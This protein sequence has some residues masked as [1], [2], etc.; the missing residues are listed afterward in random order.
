MVAIFGPKSATSSEHIRSIADSMEIPYVETRWNYRPETR[1]PSSTGYAFNLHPD[2]STLSKAYVDVLDAFH[3]KTV[4]ILYQ[5]NN[6][7]MTLRELFAK[8]SKSNEEERLKIVVKQLSKNKNGYRDVLK[9]ILMSESKLI[10]LDCEKKILSEVLKQCQQVGLINDE[11][12]FLLTSL[13]AHTVPLDDFKVC[14]NIE[15]NYINSS[16]VA[17][18]LNLLSISVRRD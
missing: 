18:Q 17:N 11:Y 12:Y 7:M 15:Q 1:G 6:S 16:G 10:V 13:D 4:T 2:V 8:T 3:W 14:T 9:E 5:D